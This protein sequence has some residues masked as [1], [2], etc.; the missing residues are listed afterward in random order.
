MVNYS[1]F[2]K[3][4]P[5]SGVLVK[6]LNVKDNANSASWTIE[7]T[8]AAGDAVFGDRDFTY[9]QLPEELEGAE[10][11]RTACESKKANTEL[12]EFTAGADAAVYIAIDQRVEN[13]QD[14]LPDWLSDYTKTGETVSSNDAKVS[15]DLYVKNV[16]EGETVV[17]GSNGT[18]QGVVNYTV[19]VVSASDEPQP[20]TEADPQ[21]TEPV[22]TAP[23]P[24]DVTV[25]ERTV[26]EDGGIVG[27]ANVDG[28]VNLNDAVAILQNVAL[29]TKY[30][31]T[32]Q[33]RINADVY[34]RGV[35]DVSG[36]DALSIQKY[37]AG[38]ISLPESRK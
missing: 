29:S 21:P 15:F 1:V 31:L 36:L 3:A 32:E 18:S 13:E 26:F 9:K 33:G 16:S 34:E 2:G 4:L 11:I 5:A 24:D 38:L 19:F 22:T 8:V 20:T 25:P 14:A 30:P 23:V 28:N 6:D 7:E 35:W 10:Y 12:A 17:L 37:D 27:D